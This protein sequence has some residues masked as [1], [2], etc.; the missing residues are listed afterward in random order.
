[1]RLVFEFFNRSN[2]LKTQK[3]SFSQLMRTAVGLILVASY[4]SIL[5]QV[6]AGTLLNFVLIIRLSF[7]WQN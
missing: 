1:M 6:T 4:F 3:M 2:D 7:Q 5:V